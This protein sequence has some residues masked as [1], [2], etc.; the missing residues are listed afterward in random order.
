MA[1]SDGSAY[2]L[3]EVSWWSGWA[4]T[5]WLDRDA[6]LFFSKDFAEYFFNR[7]GFVRVT[8]KATSEVDTME[9]EFAKRD[10]NPYIFVRSDSLDE[11]LLRQLEKKHYRIADQM[12]VMEMETPSLGLNRELVLTMG[13][14]VELVP[15]AEVYLKS[16]Y[17]DLELLD[18]VMDVLKRVSANK[19]T[20]LVLAHLEKRPVGALALHRNEGMM[21]T[22]CV[23][24]VP[25]AR[26][27]RVASTMLDFANK[28]AV[29]EGRRFILQTILSDSV[30]PLY[31][32]LGFR[33]VY[34]K[35]LFVRGQETS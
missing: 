30:E 35:E 1:D 22:Y 26:G 29:N 8:A 2:E 32:K 34:M 16:F 21:G 14:G 11:R 3:N 20:S 13:S 27:K 17:G 31:V 10:L 24:T 12:S 28:L 19:E 23:G 5:V 4:E 7:G 25:D 15:W 18:R 6:Y 33:R 9:A